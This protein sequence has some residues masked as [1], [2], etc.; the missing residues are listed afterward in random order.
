[1]GGEHGSLFVHEESSPL[2]LPEPSQTC[3]LTLPEHQIC[4]VY[5]FQPLYTFQQVT[6]CAGAGAT[7]AQ[8][9]LPAAVQWL[10]FLAVVETWYGPSLVTCCWAVWAQ[11]PLWR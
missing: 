6:S 7:G 9:A 4:P 3:L 1:M 11:C 5:T 8:P 2:H 10:S